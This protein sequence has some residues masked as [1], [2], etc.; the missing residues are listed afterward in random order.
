MPQCEVFLWTV[1]DRLV[2]AIVASYC[3]AAVINSP[4]IRKEFRLGKRAIAGLHYQGSCIDGIAAHRSV[5]L[6]V[7]IPY[8]RIFWH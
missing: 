5:L 8:R 2:A 4:C 1:V 3:A 6:S 7:L